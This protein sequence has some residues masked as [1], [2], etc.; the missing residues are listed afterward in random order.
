MDN[1]RVENPTT[2]TRKKEDSMK[3]SGKAI[4][5]AGSTVV[6]AGVQT[7]KK[8]TEVGVKTTMK[9]GELTLKAGKATGEAAFAVSK[10]TA[11]LS[12]AAAKKTA[13]AGVIVVKKTGQIVAAGVEKTEEFVA[14]QT[15]KA[16]TEI[17]KEKEKHRKNPKKRMPGI[18][19]AL[20][21]GFAYAMI[22]VY[23]R[24]PLKNNINRLFNDK[25]L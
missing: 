21:A 4:G 1:P 20:W 12:Y 13:Q 19:V 2:N 11:E 14:D 3:S 18:K 16:I 5:K 9:A 25:I 22:I 8:I 6:K 24:T 10:K 7:T 15:K 23:K 17:E